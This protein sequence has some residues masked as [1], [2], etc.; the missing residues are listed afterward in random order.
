MINFKKGGKSTIIFGKIHTGKKETCR[1][2]F[3]ESRSNF[4]AVCTRAQETVFPILDSLKAEAT[5]ST[6]LALE[7]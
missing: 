5:K 2:R 1:R 6:V 3:S 7:D 4:K